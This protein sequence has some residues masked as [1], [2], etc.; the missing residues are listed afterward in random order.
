[1]QLLGKGRKSLYTWSRPHNQDAYIKLN[2]KESS[3]P[4]LPS[5]LP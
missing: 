3:T 4:Q 5:R 1:M 2:I